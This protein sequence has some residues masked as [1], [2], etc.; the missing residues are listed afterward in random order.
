MSKTITLR[1]LTGLAIFPANSAANYFL[2]ILYEL[3]TNILLA[4]L[5]S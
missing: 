4:I 3:Q 2:A 5:A 1:Q